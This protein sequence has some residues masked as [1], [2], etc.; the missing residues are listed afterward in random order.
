MQNVFGD[1]EY[2]VKAYIGLDLGVC[3]HSLVESVE[4]KYEDV[5]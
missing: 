4:M 1:F 2:L 5:R 3:V